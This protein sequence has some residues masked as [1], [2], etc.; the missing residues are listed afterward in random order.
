MFADD[1]YLPPRPHPST[2]WKRN[3]KKAEEGIAVKYR[4]KPFPDPS[5][6]AET[7]W[8]PENQIQAESKKA[9]Q[10][11]IEAGSGN[12]GKF[13]LE[14][15]GC[16]G[17]PNLDISVA[18]RNKSDPFVLIAFEDCVV[19]TDVIND[20]LAPR[21][22]PW[23]RRAFVFNVMHPSSQFYIAVMDYEGVKS[24]HDK[25]GRVIVNPT[26]LRPDTMYTMRYSLLDSDEIDRKSTGK[27]MFR[28][29]FET[30]TN[31]QFLLSTFQ[32]RNEYHVSTTGR[33]DSQ[34]MR[35]ALTNDVSFCFGIILT[36]KIE[37][38]LIIISCHNNCPCLKIANT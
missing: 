12:V 4:I 28:L 15:L 32:L 27:I 17:L 23:T 3:E 5:R 2:L 21:W 35:F 6:E 29:R 13:Y 25:I 34:T 36:F 31:R 26:N 1:C 8:M 24:R 9:S 10:E 33:A 11:W 14:I 22:M 19:N 18:G 20:C 37:E 30:P 16:D 7:K 38:C